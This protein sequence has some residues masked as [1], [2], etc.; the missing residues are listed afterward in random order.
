MSCQKCKRVLCV[1]VC[2]LLCVSGCAVQQSIGGRSREES[3]TA[4]INE[5]V[6]S[7]MEQK[8]GEPFTYAGAS[9]NS[10]TGTHELYVSCES[11][12]D[13][14]IKVVVD[15][16][17][18]D[19]RTIRDN[20]LQYK[21]DDAIRAILEEA[22][23]RVFSDYVLY[24]APTD[25]VPE[26][27]LMADATVE[28]VFNDAGTMLNVK[29]E[30]RSSELAS[31]EKAEQ[32]M[33]AIEGYMAQYYFVFVSVDESDFGQ[34]TNEELNELLNEGAFEYSAVFTRINGN[35]RA[36]WYEGGRGRW[37]GFPL[38]FSLSE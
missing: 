12:P 15:D 16:Y 23:E 2:L 1:L 11:L 19:T 4:D 18:G 34:Y 31:I 9:G 24:Y 26:E 8:Y 7:Y 22:I 6:L 30:V 10:M 21:Y 35:V 5:Y 29:V 37:R 25:A 27:E 28:E 3:E 32:C 36:S 38:M 33:T 17:A 20:Y 14:R 13:Q